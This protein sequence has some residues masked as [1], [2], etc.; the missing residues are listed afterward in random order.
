MIQYDQP[1]PTAGT[2]TQVQLY[3]NLVGT[4]E[5]LIYREGPVG[6]F[7]IIDRTGNFATA[8]GLNTQATSMAVQA[9]DYLAW[10]PFQQPW[11]LFDPLVV[12]YAIAFG[13]LQLAITLL[14]WS[15]EVSPGAHDNASGVATVLTL[16]EHFAQQP[17]QLRPANGGTFRQNS[18]GGGT[19]GVCGAG[20]RCR[21]E[22]RHL[23]L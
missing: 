18:G 6:T 7:T 8:S 17:P 13:T 2:V 23:R 1:F 20:N 19:G 12:A 9:G 21:F 16:A 11:W 10:Y 22:F 4:A 15:K 5:V 14:G 3:L